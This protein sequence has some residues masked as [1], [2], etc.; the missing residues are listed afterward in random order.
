MYFRKQFLLTV[1][2]WC[3]LRV[4]LIESA[5]EIKFTTTNIEEILR[6]SFSVVGLCRVGFAITLLFPC[7]P[8]ALEEQDKRLTFIPAVPVIGERLARGG[9]KAAM[10]QITAE[11]LQDFI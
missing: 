4:G 2:F 8:V 6:G 7:K 10:A 5:A 1:E 3:P 9:L 11:V